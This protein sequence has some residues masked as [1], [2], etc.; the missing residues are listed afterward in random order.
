[1]AGTIAGGI[2][3]RDTNYNRY[4]RDFYVK[5]GMLGGKKSRTGG[6][7]STCIGKDGLTGRERARI[8]GAKGGTVS[9]KTKS[10]FNLGA[11]S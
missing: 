11:Q 4:G 8:V 6:F 5:L 1:M 7:A 9:R 10:T 3:A 2:S